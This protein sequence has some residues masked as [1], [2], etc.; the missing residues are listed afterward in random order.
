VSARWLALHALRHRLGQ[1]VVLGLL[2]MTAIAACAAGPLYER[3]VEQAAVRSQLSHAGTADRGVTVQASSAGEAQ[4]YLPAGSQRAVFGPPVAGVETNVSVTAGRTAFV[5]IAAGR[6]DLCAHLRI[7]QGSCPSAGAQVLLST[8]S[9]GAF[10]LAVGSVLTITGHGG[11]GAYPIGRVRIVG[12]YQPFGAG[13]DYWFNRAYSTT[14][15]IVRQF[16]GD[17]PDI[18][19]SDALLTGPAGIQFFEAARATSNVGGSS[20]FQYLVDL[21]VSASRIGVEQSHRLV[22]ALDGIQARIDAAHPDGDPLRGQLTSKLGTLLNQAETGRHQSRVIIPTL[23]VQLALVVLVVLGLVLAVGIDQR[24]PE[25]ALAR[26]RGQSRA[27]AARLY[28]AEIAVIVA[29][30]ILPG[31][32]LAWLGCELLCRWWLPDGVG[33]ELRW[34]MFA[35]GIAVAAVELLLA[36]VLA[37]RAAA[38]PIGELLRSV[39]PRRSGRGVGVAE[40]AVGVAATAGVV[41][42]V[43][44]DRTSTVSLLA[45]SLIAILAGLLLSRAL[46]ALARLAG[47]RA[48][49]RGRL[50]LALAALQ[51]ARRPGFRRVVTLVCVAVALLVSSVDQWSVSGENRQ[52]RAAATVGAAV[53][54]EVNAPSAAALQSTVDKADPL[55]TYAMPVII[56]RPDGGDTPVIA[57]DHQRLRAIADWGSSRDTPGAGTVRALVPGAP[58]AAIRLSGTQLRLRV[59]DVSLV[60]ADPPPSQRP[61]PVSLSLRF[62]L[63]DGSLTTATLPVA[64]GPGPAESSAPLGGC[65]SGC[66]LNRIQLVR[67]VGDFSGAKVSL[68]LLGLQAGTASAMKPVALGNARDWQNSDA[69]AAAAGTAASISFLPAPGGALTLQA[70][71]H[72]S[73]ATLQHLDVPVNLPCLIA[74][75]PVVAATPDA[76]VVNPV[77]APNTVVTQPDSSISMHGIDGATASCQPAGTIAFVPKVGSPALITDLALEIASSQPVLTNS[78]AEVWLGRSDPAREATLTRALAVAGITVLG[79]STSANQ[80]SIY[81]QS[82]PAWSIRAALATAVLAALIAALMVVIAAFTSERARS[83]DLAS[84]RL[85]GIGPG[86]LRRAVLIEQLAGVLFALVLGS[87]VGVFG[88][89]LALPAVPLFVSPATLPRPRYDLAWTAVSIAVIAVLILLVL[90]AFVGAFV[91]GRRV[92]PDRLR[93]AA[94]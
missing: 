57:V 69:A 26:L 41:V 80:Q 23:A 50:A 51:A 49:W 33:P 92:S 45:P 10:R 52:A 71:S 59:A 68:R 93:E 79:R 32:L 29:A 75:S 38:A 12:L 13:N 36:V 15:G 34:P 60:S 48:L 28:I 37:R 30:A 55:G 11:S 4:S 9:A 54:L 85:V 78:S 46:L 70:V 83:Y 53:V 44:G 91:I 76:G 6:D 14:A 65:A 3:A 35:A 94:R 56:Q 67:S 22:Q 8:S 25:L 73:G 47:R 86:K 58:A 24:R 62:Q 19:H 82:P 84:L 7:V 64:T 88:A 16:N 74:G 17:A 1:S 27:A 21:P 39:P 5:A 63:A 40:A 42:A 87:V 31:L 90:A 18:L 81:D 77:A 20:P 72:G 61:L 2:S 66:T 43:S 89:R